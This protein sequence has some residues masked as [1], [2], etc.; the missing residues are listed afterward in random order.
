M[1]MD[2]EITK[3]DLRREFNKG[4]QKGIKDAITKAIKLAEKSGD[5]ELAKQLAELSFE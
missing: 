2:N 1:I 3:F 4:Y 5:H